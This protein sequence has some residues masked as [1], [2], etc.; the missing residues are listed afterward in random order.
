MENIDLGKTQITDKIRVSSAAI[1]YEYDNYYQLE[2]WIFSDDKE[3]QKSRQ[4][5]HCTTGIE[6]PQTKIDEVKKVHKLISD[7]LIK[8]I[9]QN[10]LTPYQRFQMV[11][12]GNILPEVKN[13]KDEDLFESGLEELNRLA[14]WTESLAEMETLDQ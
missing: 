6:I 11:H 12:Y 14:E 4:V 13:T 2:T 7:N 5:I 3:V 1:W 10:N 8:K 9:M